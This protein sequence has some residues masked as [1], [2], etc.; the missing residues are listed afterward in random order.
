MNDSPA[1]DCSLRSW[2][3]LNDDQRGKLTRT[4]I[5]KVD[6]P[7]SCHA[8][9]TCS[10]SENYK[11]D[12]VPT[13]MKHGA[14]S[15]RED[16]IPVE[17]IHGY[18]DKTVWIGT[19]RWVQHWCRLRVKIE[20][21]LSVIRINCTATEVQDWRRSTYIQTQ[22]WPRYS[23]FWREIWSETERSQKLRFASTIPAICLLRSSTKS[24]G[25]RWD[26][27]FSIH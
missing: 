22:R 4:T 23:F 15:C 24:P 18:L 9:V 11:N 27:V 16:I 7:R 10:G 8:F 3:E 17:Q 26:I 20:H 5:A 2:G 21:E 1:M 14:I 13:Y 12:G 19:T 6:F 25:K